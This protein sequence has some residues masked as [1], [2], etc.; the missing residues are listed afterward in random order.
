M[1]LKTAVSVVTAVLLY[2]A[3]GAVG[4]VGLPVTV[5]ALLL[6]LLGKSLA[7][8]LHVNVLRLR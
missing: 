7:L 4:W 2:L 1:P 5:G 6:L 8:V 3:L